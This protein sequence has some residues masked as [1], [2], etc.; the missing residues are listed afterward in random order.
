MKFTQT[1][2][3]S[4]IHMQVLLVNLGISE[5]HMQVLLVNLIFFVFLCFSLIFIDFI[6]FP[7]GSKQARK[8]SRKGRKQGRKAGRSQDKIIDFYWFFKGVIKSHSFSLC[9]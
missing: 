2:A 3:L 1:S 4:E 8:E 9:F 5:I 7:E 6:R